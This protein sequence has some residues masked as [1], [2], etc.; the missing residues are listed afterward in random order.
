MNGAVES[1]LRYAD[2]ALGILKRDAIVF[3]SYRMR[4]FSQ[5]VSLLFSVM[6]F[7]YISRLLMVPRS[8]PP[9]PTSPLRW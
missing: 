4:F 6:L 3:V 1:W 8:S 2:G 7:Y 9:T 5:A